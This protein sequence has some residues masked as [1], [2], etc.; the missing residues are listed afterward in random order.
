MQPLMHVT[1]HSLTVRVS[2]V[3]VYMV[4]VICVRSDLRSRHHDVLEALEQ[5]SNENKT[6]TLEREHESFVNASLR[7]KLDG[8]KQLAQHYFQHV[9]SDF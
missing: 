5:A 6:L 2:F 9:T 4:M 1:T 3:F 7:R 8:L